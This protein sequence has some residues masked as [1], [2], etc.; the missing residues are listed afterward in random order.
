MI[1]AYFDG[2]CAPENPKGHMGFGCLVKEDNK[3][4]YQYGG[5]VEKHESNSNNLAEYLALENVLD[6]LLENGYEDDNICI[7]GDSQLVIMQMMNKW[8]IKSG[9]YVETAKSCKAKVKVFDNI[10]L[11][12]IPREQNTECDELSKI[13]F[14]KL[15][16]ADFSDKKRKKK[17]KYKI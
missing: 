7:F 13:T 16:I 6:F 2:A 17:T 14:V 9:R 8:K 1:T 11:K 4:V 15:G 10:I 12:W 3:I 5:Y